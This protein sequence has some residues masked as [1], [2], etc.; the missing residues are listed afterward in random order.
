[1][2]P[3]SI[4]CPNSHGRLMDVAFSV[5]MVYVKVFVAMLYTGLDDSIIAVY[6]L[7]V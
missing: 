7:P 5:I 1:M 6:K 2:V 3:T 4:D